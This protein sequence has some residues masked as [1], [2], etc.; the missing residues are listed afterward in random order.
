[1]AW[2]PSLPAS[3][4]SAEILRREGPRT[5]AACAEVADHLPARRERLAELVLRH[6]I[7]RLDG[8][9]SGPRSE[10]FSL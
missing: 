6:A 4:A 5:Q 3:E 7:C 10:A 1:M 2:A 8:S 9:W